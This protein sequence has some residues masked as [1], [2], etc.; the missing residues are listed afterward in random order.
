ML[1]FGALLSVAVMACSGSSIAYSDLDQELQQAR[2]ARFARCG[3]SPSEASCMASAR[4]IPDASLAGAITAHKVDYDGQRAKQ[5]VDAIAKQSCDLTAHDAHF[6]PE[7]CAEM[8]TG[9]V[10]GGDSCSID[11]ECASATCELPELCPE[12]G[13]CVGACRPAQAPGEAGAAC[14][15]ARDC[16][17]GLVCGADRTCHRQVAAGES[18]GSD[19]ECGD[20]LA[21]IG[22]SSLMPG[23]CRALPHVGEPCP[24][25]RC[26]DVNL[27]CDDTKTH[28]CVALG[29]SGEPCTIST[30]CGS[31]LEC[32]AATH[33]CRDVP[34]LGMPCDSTCGGDSFCAFDSGGVMGTCVAPFANSSPCDGYNQCASFYCE[35]GPIFDSCKD[36]Y[37]CF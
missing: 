30:E 32:D 13:C 9:K 33:L 25:L 14:A 28:T 3:L 8:F 22:A 34:T 19:R 26:A 11:A 2:C 5:C 24:Y 20:G 17:Q 1:R 10:T 4:I 16:T 23:N 31:S 35:Q 29:L 18:C 27:R 15:K 36:P 12:T 7:A 21:C 6:E 37:V